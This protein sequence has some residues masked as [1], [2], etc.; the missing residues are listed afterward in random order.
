MH[1]LTPSR[2]S[3]EQASDW[4]L[5]L[6]A[7][8]ARFEEF[9]HWLHAS[10]EHLSAWAQ[11]N[12]AWSAIEQPSTTAHWPASTAVVQLK[13]SRR[14]WSMLAA[15]CVCV[16]AVGVAWLNNPDWQAD[17]HTGTG[18]TRVVQLSDGSQLT[19]AARSAVDVDYSGNT[20]HITLLSGEALFDVAHDARRPF[21]VDASNVVIRVLG[22]SFDVARSETGTKV[23]VREGAVGV[24]ANGS[25]YRLGAGQRLWFDALQGTVQ[26]TA[27]APDEV[28]T[29]VSGQQ[30][31]ENATVQEVVEQLRKYQRGWI[32]IGDNALGQKR[33][34]GLYDLRDTQRALQALA[35]PIGG[36]LVRYSPLLTVLK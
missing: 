2:A 16:I 10:P 22:T 21:Q 3:L 17:Y 5:E 32:V 7:E 26:Q 28:A 29:W 6:Q 36:T 18:E 9:D 25:P 15:A 12:R 31:F 8:P 27:I 14:K 30:F 34:T 13:A 11:V 23:E 33:V 24:S 19:L 4:L 35:K 1:E 20:R